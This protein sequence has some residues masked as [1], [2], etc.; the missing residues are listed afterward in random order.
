MKNGR[1]VNYHGRGR[2]KTAKIAAQIYSSR[3]EAKRAAE[4][5]FTSGEVEAYVKREIQGWIHLYL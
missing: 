1:I 5:A 2:K 4:R 3:E